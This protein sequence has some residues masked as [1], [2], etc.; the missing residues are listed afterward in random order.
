MIISEKENNIVNSLENGR[1]R[2]TLT[3]PVNA[4]ENPRHQPSDHNFVILLVEDTEADAYTVQRVLAKMMSYKCMILRATT[5][6]EAERI[7]Q[8]RDD[9]GLV[10]LDLGLPDSVGPKETYQRFETYKDRFPIVIL[11]SLEDHTTAL[12]ILEIGA[13]D[14]VCK[15]VIVGQPASL[16]RT[17][18][19][20]VGRHH[21]IA[22]TRR[23]ML[24]DLSKKDDLL[25]LMT[26]GYSV[27]H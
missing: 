5:I 7:I 22:K 26:G 20:A 17:V 13:Q 21:S 24:D 2:D 9:I 14:Y 19:F 15:Q 3:H 6:G 25:H 27:M 23:A 11:T 12:D 10:L 16:V 18:E 4:R 8:D 1:D